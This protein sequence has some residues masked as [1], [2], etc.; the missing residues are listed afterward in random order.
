MNE[1]KIVKCEKCGTEYKLPADYIEYNEQV[2]ERLRT[3]IK[4]RRIIETPVK[5]SGPCPNCGATN[6]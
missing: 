6:H 1:Y 5:V 4:Q 2:T 3:G